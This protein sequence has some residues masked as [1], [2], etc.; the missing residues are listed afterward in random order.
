RRLAA[1]V[2]PAGLR[3][4]ALIYCPEILRDSPRLTRNTVLHLVAYENGGFR[5]R[6]YADGHRVEV[7]EVAGI[8]KTVF[9]QNQYSWAEFEFDA[10]EASTPL[11]D[12]EFWERRIAAAN[13][14]HAKLLAE[15]K[16]VIEAG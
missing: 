10:E 16:A 1:K 14:A 3:T 13:K 5:L 12:N 7:K 11:T 8:T 2:A 9:L 4:R 6:D 15:G